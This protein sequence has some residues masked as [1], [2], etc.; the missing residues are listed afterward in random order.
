MKKLII[1]AAA[2]AI[3]TGAF[4]LCGED[5]P[6]QAVIVKAAARTVYTFKF[7]GKTTK[8]L[9]HTDSVT[10]GEDTTCIAR[11]PAK[12]KIKGW[13]ATCG[14]LCTEIDEGTAAAEAY[15][16]WMLKPYKGWFSTEDTVLAFVGDD[17][18][19]PNVIGK[20]PN[21]AEAAG[22]L[23]GTILFAGVGADAASWVWAQG[24]GIVFAGLG[25]YKAPIYKKIKGNFAGAP[26]ASWYISERICDQTHVYDCATLTLDCENAPNT[27]AFGKWQMKYSKSASKKF[28]GK[29]PKTPAWASAAIFQK[30]G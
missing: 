2:A 16:F 3:S 15:A 13:I 10:C 7:T 12:L 24:S 22:E 25:K 11:I 29:L 19:L 17:I 26:V 4:A 20:K 18:K 30:E 14:N 9:P 23:Y 5:A 6:V 28:P 8:G 27:V 21:K 1:A